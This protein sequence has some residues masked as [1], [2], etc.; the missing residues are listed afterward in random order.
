MADTEDICLGGELWLRDGRVDAAWLSKVLGCSVE[1]AKLRSKDS[2]GGI[3]EDQAVL[4]LDVTL[5]DAA[6]K[7]L[8]I[9]RAVATPT[10]QSLGIAR[11]AHFFNELASQLDVAM[12][13]SYY[14]HGDLATGAKVVLMEY[15]EDALPAGLCFGPGN[16]N[17]WNS[18]I[19]LRPSD[20]GPEEIAQSAF[21]EYARLHARFWRGHQLPT[22]SWLRGQDWVRGEGQAA[23]E[24]AQSMAKDAWQ[25]LCL[26]RSGGTAKI[27]WDPHLVACMESSMAKISWHSFQAEL[28]ERPWTLVQGDCHPH[29]ALW[30]RD[31]QGGRLV[32]IDFEMVGLGS[33]AQELGQF[34]ISHMEP[35]ARRANE[36]ALVR[37]YFDELLNALRRQGSDEAESLRFDSIWTE[38]VQG[39]A[40]RWLW[41]VA[42]L[43]KNFPENM[44]Q[45]FHDQVASFLHDH[46]PDPSVMGMP[47]V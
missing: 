1:E 36:K 6:R 10:A 2:V 42:Y 44:G 4:L 45:F 41:F 13:R 11:E 33:P 22:L 46:V 38:Y 37:T 47:R 29:N 21:K 9:K 14:A 8:L 26:E 34:V 25:A 18:S 17:C 23:W 19:E 15:F 5:K 35:S 31:P 20:P 16:P 24:A 28:Q 27:R 43:C 40:C 12:P 39:G 3:R 30:I 32:I 7:T